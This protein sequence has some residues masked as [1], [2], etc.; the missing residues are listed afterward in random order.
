M[1]RSASSATCHVDSPLVSLRAILGKDNTQVTFL[2]DAIRCP[3]YT[4]IV[5]IV[6][7]GIMLQEKPHCLLV[8]SPC[9]PV[10]CSPIYLE[11][12][13]EIKWSKEE[14]KPGRRSASASSSQSMSKPESEHKTP[15]FSPVSQQQIGIS[16]LLGNGMVRQH[17]E[18]LARIESSILLLQRDQSE[19][20]LNVSYPHLKCHLC[21]LF[22]FKGS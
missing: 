10:E 18:G 21:V 3:P 17:W 16:R 9:S 12:K 19:A 14:G 6:H 20:S 4:Y 5:L 1:V 11:G 22:P 8:P 7:S 15:Q 2:I 13:E